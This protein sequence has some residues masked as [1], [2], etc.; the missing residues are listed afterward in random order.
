MK[1]PKIKIVP[2]CKD[3]RCKELPDGRCP[4]CNKKVKK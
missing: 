3:T 1:L 2:Y 4:Y